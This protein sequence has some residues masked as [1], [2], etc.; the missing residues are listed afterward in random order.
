MTGN[1]SRLYRI[2]T[3]VP[4][5][6][7]AVSNVN[8]TATQ[9]NADTTVNTE[10]QVGGTSEAPQTLGDSV[11]ESFASLKG[12]Y[13]ESLG[14]IESRLERLASGDPMRIGNHFAETVS[15][16]LD[17]ARWSMSVMGVDNSAKAGTNTV[18][19]LTK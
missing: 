1:V 17:V 18:K 12:G 6:N 10:M 16:Q 19:E 11:L 14:V 2:A 8:T 4:P 13:D 3:G 15:L 7:A 5:Q 9:V